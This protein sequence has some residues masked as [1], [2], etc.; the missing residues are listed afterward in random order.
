MAEK[1]DFKK[2]QDKWQPKWREMKLYK[3]SEDKSREKFYCL[4]FFPYP[5][6]NGLSVGHLRNYIPTDVVSRMKKMQGLN[7]LH[8][9]G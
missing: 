9:M 2:L 4:D 6:G 3:T 5:S 7:V 1:Y 8:P